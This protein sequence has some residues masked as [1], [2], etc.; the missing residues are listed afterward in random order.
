MRMRVLL[1]SLV[2]AAAVAGVPA[3]AGAQEL[4][5]QDF[6]IPTRGI[7]TTGQ[8]L[9]QLVFTIANWIFAAF[10]AVSIIFVILAAFDFILAQGNEDTIKGARQKLMYAAIG[11][12]IA[13]LAN[14]FP[15]IVKS[16]IIG[17]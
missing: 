5:P 2:L 11:I 6:Q 13:M 14:S 16:I 4:P 9:L 7:P 1:A 8:D 15:E 17:A 10:L 3:P 12:G